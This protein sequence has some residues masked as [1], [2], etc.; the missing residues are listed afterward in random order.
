MV[1]V[2]LSY[3][4]SLETINRVPCK[5]AAIKLAFL[6][7]WPCQKHY[8]WIANMVKQEQEIYHTK[9]HLPQVTSI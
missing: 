2:I 3:N 5:R 6:L 4:G 1:L 9:D 8:M 7:S